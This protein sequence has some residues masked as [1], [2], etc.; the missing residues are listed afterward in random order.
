MK[1]TQA[2]GIFNLQVSCYCSVVLHHFSPYLEY[3]L[4]ADRPEIKARVRQ[5]VQKFVG[6][7]Q[8]WW[9]KKKK[10]KNQ[11][12]QKSRQEDLSNMKKIVS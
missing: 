7:V 4:I 12:T 3:I 9:Q 1:K 5:R 11:K 8:L 2:A 6:L 10:N